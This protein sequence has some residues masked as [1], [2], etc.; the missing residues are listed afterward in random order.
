MRFLVKLFMLLNVAMYRL[1]GNK[2]G[3]GV[4]TLVTKNQVNVV[5]ISRIEAL[6]HS[7]IIT[8]MVN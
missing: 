3:R 7:I 8:K 6:T 4:I 1:S 5:K 2:L